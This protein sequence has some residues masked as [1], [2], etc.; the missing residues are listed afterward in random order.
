MSGEGGHPVVDVH[1]HIVPDVVLDAG[2]RGGVWHGVELGSNQSGTLTWT[3]GGNTHAMG[4]A[5]LLSLD[6][7]LQTMDD[8]HVDVQLLSHMPAMFWYKS[9]KDTATARAREIN[10]SIAG[11]VAKAPTRLRQL[12]HLPLQ[13]PDDAL[14]EL[15]RAATELDVVGLGIG[16]NVDGLN[17]D[18]PELFPVLEAAAD[19]G[20]MVF[21]HPCDAR[22]PSGPH[23]Y[24]LQNMTAFPFETT[25]AMASL[26]FGGV[27]DRLPGLR[28]CLAHGG[29]YSCMALGRFD[30]GHSVRR[31][32]Q[33]TQH[34]PSSYA[35][36]IWFDS[37][38]HSHRALRFILDQAGPGQIVLGTDFPADMAQDRPVDWV[39][40]TD[41][42][43]EQE[44]ETVLSANVQ[45]L[46]GEAAYASLRSAG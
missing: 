27:L 20:V 12:V 22:Y 38:T 18:A 41:L 7:R 1:A 37:L 35:S 42:L 32:A 33:T 4:P 43:T 6:D 19:L 30:H 2:R 10:D 31:E 26:I 16:T 28:V 36:R 8:H 40:A 3:V 17:W 24:H 44:K 13:N 14:V 11:T 29:G 25:F 21:I 5:F 45:V 15:D 34:D 9:P 39:R 23:P 46:L